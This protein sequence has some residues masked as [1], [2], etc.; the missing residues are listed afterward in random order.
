[1]GPSGYSPWLVEGAVRLGADR[2]FAPASAVL[3]HFTGVTMPPATL[4]RLTIAAGTTLRQLEL[5]HSAA[6]WAG[7]E[8]VDPVAD[9]PRQLS[10]DGSM[11]PLTD[12]WHEVKLAAIGERRGDGLAALS[13]TATL[14]DGATF[15]HEALGELARRGVPS[16]T[17]V[18]AV[19][20]GAEWI[21]GILDLHCPQAQRVLDFA[22]AAGY[23]ATT[24]TAAYGEGTAQAQDWFAAQRHTLHHDNPEVVL[25]ALLALGEAGQT[26]FSYLAARREQITYRDFVAHDWPIGSGCV[27]SAHKGIVQARLKGPG[28]RW[29]RTAA[30]GLLAIRVVEANGRWEAT[31]PQVT[32]HQRAEQRAATAARQAERGP[33]APPAKRVQDGRP[34]ADHPW[35]RFR[36]PGSPHFHHKI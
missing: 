26:A 35:R 24:A 31:W 32:P 36:L 15:A 28:M 17:D 20:D 1:M 3:Q 27:E 16:A 12:G 21:Q 5:A 25:D 8:P 4:R 23:L 22:H 11:V 6:A 9:V 19:N 29:S 10:V 14:G 34:T 2:P 33:H 30:A 13:Y 7:Q 18:V